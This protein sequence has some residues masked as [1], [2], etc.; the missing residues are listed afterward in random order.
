MADQLVQKVK[1][2]FFLGITIIALE[3]EAFTAL[4]KVA[5]DDVYIAIEADKPW[6]IPPGFLQWGKPAYKRFNQALQ[7]YTVD[8]IL[9]KL[10]NK[11]PELYSVIITHPR[12]KVWLEA[13][14]A[15]L[16]KQLS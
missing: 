3:R 7:R 12:G 8:Y 16:R 10:R 1:D 6:T 4:E 5:P 13:R 2:G 14:L 9:E 11:R 15:E